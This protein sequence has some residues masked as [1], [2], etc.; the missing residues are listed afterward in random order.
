MRTG[1]FLPEHRAPAAA[2]LAVVAL[3][4]LTALGASGFVAV[5]VVSAD[6][7]LLGLSLGIALAS[8]SAALLI[9]SNRLVPQ[10]EEVEDRGSL[11]HP[12]EQREVVG[13]VEEAAGGLTRRRLVV[14]A[15]GA[16][17]TALA[18]AVVVPAASLGPFLGTDRLL[19]GPWRPG[20][21]L[22][23]EDGRPI[24]ADDVVEGSFLT[25]FPEGAPKD[26]LDAPLVVVRLPV[27]SLELPPGREDWAPRGILA[28]SK[29]CPHA[30]CAVSLY[31]H[32]LY[33]PTAAEP[34][35]VC[36]CHY[37]TFDPT[38][39]GELTFG[40]AGRPL[41]QLPLRLSPEGVL[42]AAG[43]FPDGIGPSWWGVRSEP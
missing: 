21:R 12:D 19:R 42:E 10:E 7:Q 9:A 6:T 31:R 1:R 20:R 4:G 26:T 3:L 15:A 27:E 11:L 39:G 30:G 5:Y 22:V 36:P 33:D 37:S 16:A 2:E 24:T 41:P 17:G 13:L 14:A 38:R 18:A 28:F 23:R 25:A 40:P 43:P 32:P 8:L 35:L 34:A 29:T